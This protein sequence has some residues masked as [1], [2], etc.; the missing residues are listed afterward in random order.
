MDWG[1]IVGGLLGAGSEVALA[2][3]GINKLEQS[4]EDIQTRLNQVAQQAQQGLEFKPYTVTTGGAGGGLGTFTAGPTGTSATLSDDYKNIVQQLTGAGLSGM[5]GGA[6]PIDSRAADITAAM[7]A[8]ANPMRERERLALEERLLSQGRLG[9][10]TD[11][12]GGTPEQLALA[13]AIE[14][15]RAGNIVTG[16]QQALGEQLQQ[17][18]IGQ[19]MFNNSFTPQQQLMNLMQTTTPFAELAT[20]AQQQQAV[21]GA[22][23]GRTGAEAAIQSDQLANAL[24]LAY[25]QQALQGL[26]SPTNVFQNGQQTTQASLFS[27][28]WD[29]IF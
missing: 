15:Q 9:V 29:K 27:G 20:R 8:A 23:L 10:R 2:N 16:R 26:F 19:G 1:Q 13:K 22:E 6:A 17:Y 24:R 21:T 3:Y 14:E 4:G 18:N 25:M 7:E 28:L 11:A 12:Y 5:L